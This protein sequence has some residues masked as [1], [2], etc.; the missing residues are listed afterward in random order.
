VMHIQNKEQNN[1]Y[2]FNV[3]ELNILNKRQT[4]RLQKG[5]RA[6]FKLSTRTH[7]R[8]KDINRLKIKVS[9]QFC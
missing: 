6:V 2:K 1:S 3:N 4:G 8:F 9:F 7:V 5:A